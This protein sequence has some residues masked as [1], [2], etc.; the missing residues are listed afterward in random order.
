MLA[1]WNSVGLELLFG[2]VT[3]DTP[4]PKLVP[5]GDA[6]VD[7]DKPPIPSFDLPPGI[8]SWMY[9]GDGWAQRVGQ[10]AAKKRANIT[11]TVPEGVIGGE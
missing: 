7:A 9:E 6:F 4:T 2:A 1:Q 5:Y 10:T 8:P 3:K 11:I